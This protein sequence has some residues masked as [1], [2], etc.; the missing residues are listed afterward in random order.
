MTSYVIYEVD[1]QGSAE[2]IHFMNSLASDLFPPLQ[3]HHLETGFW[4]CVFHG[5]D[6]IVGMAGMV[7]FEPFTN[8]GYLKR[9][10]ILPDHRGHGLQ[11]RLLQAREDHAR[12]LGWTQLV[13]ETH[14]N[15]QSSGRNFER[16]GYR[17]CEPEQKWVSHPA[18]YWVKDL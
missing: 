6:H 8:V 9:C 15:N 4:W 1:A 3:D 14:L 18:I 7:P 17:K 11:L 5:P 16:A 10:Y 2:A 13:S 12:Q